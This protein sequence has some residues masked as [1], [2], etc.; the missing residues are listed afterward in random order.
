VILAGG[1]GE[2]M[3]SAGPRVALTTG[4]LNEATFL[5][6]ALR[7]VESVN[8]LHEG[9]G[10][11]GGAGSDGSN[12]V[13][14]V[15]SATLSPVAALLRSLNVT[16]NLSGVR[17]VTQSDVPGLSDANCQLAHEVD[18]KGEKGEMKLVTKPHGHGDVHAL[19]HA[20]GVLP[21]WSAAN[22]SHVVFLQ[23]SNAL[24]YNSLIS[25]VGVSVAERRDI[26]TVAIR[27]KGGDS[28]GAL[29]EFTERGTVTGTSRSVVANIEYNE[30]DAIL[31]G[32]DVDDPATGYS[33]YPGNSNNFVVAL[34][35]Y[36]EVLVRTEGRVKEFINPKY[37]SDRVKFKKTARLE[38]LMQDIV[39]DYP[40][41][42]N[43]GYTLYDNWLVHGVAKNSAE[44]GKKLIERGLYG[45]TLG[46][47]EARGY[48]CAKRIVEG[49]H[50]NVVRSEE[51]GVVKRG[52]GLYEGARIDLGWDFY[53][54]SGDADKIR[55]CAFE[56][57][58]WTCI[59]G[60]NVF[61]SNVTF[62]GA[63]T[64]RVCEGATLTVADAKFENKGWQFQEL[65]D[66]EMA[67]GSIKESDRVRGYRLIRRETEVFEVKEPGRWRIG[68]DRV[69]QRELVN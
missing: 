41:T 68:M 16:M 17:L 10:E 12:V 50:G 30:L 54:T 47:A 24:I 67:W 13:I 5:E 63:A 39:W 29:A 26:N 38:C 35:P 28:L 62:G 49:G 40:S 25:A 32:G 65:S 60:K 69:L 66:E 3:G 36:A 11:G 27:R 33:R 18:E 23:D 55:D 4:S 15:S 46:E 42:A 19:L 37:D 56:T 61:M 44:N 21:E 6:T 58:S 34:E 64:F 52:I 57:N 51:G 43:I 2:R 20:S 48:E 9:G 45:G 31:P 7:F 1:L 8:G 22:T 53:Q 14:M 59:R